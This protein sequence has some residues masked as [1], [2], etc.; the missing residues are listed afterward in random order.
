MK[1][2]DL[3]NVYAYKLTANFVIAMGENEINNTV[4][5]KWEAEENRH[6][7]DGSYSNIL[8]YI[9]NDI[10]NAVVNHFSF[11]PKELVIDGEIINTGNAETIYITI[12]VYSNFYRYIEDDNYPFL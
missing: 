7:D 2:R 10:S 11:V 6:P 1:V 8:H 3:I 4:I 5:F 9:P 12:P